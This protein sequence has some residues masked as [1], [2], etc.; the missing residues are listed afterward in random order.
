M[1]RN[2]NNLNVKDYYIGL[3]VGTSSVGFATT[4]KDYV[5]K[6]HNGKDMWGV[7][8][9][10]EGETAQARRVNRTNRRRLSRRNQRLELLRQLFD[11]EISK[12]DSGFFMRLKESFLTVDAKSKGTKYSLF[13]LRRPFRL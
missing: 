8:L 2:G 4:D 10:D 7:R 5:I 3:D 12:I 9:F 13:H 6:R 11:E 1:K